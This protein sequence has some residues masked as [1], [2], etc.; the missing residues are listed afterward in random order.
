MPGS[1]PFASEGNGS[2]VRDQ[3]R[4]IK[5][6]AIERGR[7]TLRDARD[8]AAT[9]L[10]EGKNQVADQIGAVAHAFREA[11]TQLRTEGQGQRLAGLT[12]A[13]ARQADQAADYLRRADGELLRQDVE[14][15]ARRQPAL[16]LGSAFVA[17]L[18]G[19]RFL[20]SSERR[21]A[22]HDQG[23][24]ESG[25]GTQSM[26]GETAGVY[27]TPGSTVPASYTSDVNRPIGGIDA[28]R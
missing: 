6:Q 3:V 26:V 28:G 22:E 11:G 21:R 5:N 27:R 18:L 4:G 10:G 17:G 7:T 25:Y 16:V 9:S 23:W 8:R 13:M 2:S 19:A 20:K 14:R 12:D 15:L 24:E 1:D